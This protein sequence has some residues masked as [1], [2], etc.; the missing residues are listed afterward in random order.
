MSVRVV[1]RARGLP[2]WCSWRCSRVLWGVS[3]RVRQGIPGGGF[4]SGSCAVV[5][6]VDVVEVVDGVG[7][8]G[9][10]GGVGPGEGGVGVDAHGPAG[11]LLGA[12][13][14]AAEAGEVAGG[15]GAC[16]PGGEV[17]EVAEPGGD[18]AAGEPAPPVA[19]LDQ[20]GEA[21]SGAG[22]RSVASDSPSSTRAPV[23][24]S[25]AATRA[26]AVRGMCG[27][28]RARPGRPGPGRWCRARRP[29]RGRRSGH[30]PVAGPHRGGR[31]LRG[32]GVGRCRRGEDDLDV[33]GRVAGDEVGQRLGAGPVDPLTR[34]VGHVPLRE[35]V[36]GRP[37]AAGLLGR[38]RAQ[39]GVD[40]G[41]VDPPPQRRLR[42]GPRRALPQQV[43]A[44]SGPAARRARRRSRAPSST[45]NH[46]SSDATTVAATS[47][48]HSSSSA[49]TT[50]ARYASSRP[51][52]IAACNP[53][54]PVH[55]SVP[56]GPSAAVR[57]ACR[58]RRSAATAV[59]FSTPDRIDGASN[60]ACPSGLCT[61]TTVPSSHHCGSTAANRTTAAS[62]TAVASFTR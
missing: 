4:G 27:P 14:A 60:A 50:C 52:A 45:S 2:R 48:G 22:T 6:S 19:G 5:G 17:V 28:G 13:V 35:G 38:E 37:R 12:V 26:P 55:D 44:R 51:A 8:A 7:G 15:G 56:S 54:R 41:L 10:A 11:A 49:A 25:H 40:P 61:S 42:P 20:L 62:C 36:D 59:R 23:P 47:A 21:S 31:H 39:P 30:P 32:L 33:D 53:P 24:G 9:P 18:V 1:G 34:A 29:R 57:S 58:T 16:R 46:P 43:R 3:G